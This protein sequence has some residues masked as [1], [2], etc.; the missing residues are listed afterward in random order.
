MLH[1]ERL[2]RGCLMV[3]LVPEIKLYSVG[4]TAVDG[5]RHFV[6]PNSQERG[7]YF[8]QK[9]YPAARKA[10][11][12]DEEEAAN[13][14]RPSQTEFSFWRTLS[15]AEF[16]QFEMSATAKSLQAPAPC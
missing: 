3:A 12:E 10:S 14:S 4:C 15:L 6:L 9:S 16:A 11:E 8:W 2:F 13:F 1:L 5:R 7:E